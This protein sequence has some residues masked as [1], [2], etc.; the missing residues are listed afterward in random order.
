M[1]VS[2]IWARNWAFFNKLCKAGHFFAPKIMMTSLP[3]DQLANFIS[4]QFE[5]DILTV[6]F[7]V[8]VTVS[9]VIPP[10]S[11]IVIELNRKINMVL[12]VK[13]EKKVIFKKM[14]LK[15]HELS[16]NDKKQGFD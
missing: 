11:Q 4:L 13:N 16:K 5:S 7:M 9:K 2:L 1:L 14:K 15:S 3:R 10:S 6:V 12:W 8:R